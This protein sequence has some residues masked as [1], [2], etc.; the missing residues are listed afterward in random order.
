MGMEQEIRQLFVKF[1]ELWMLVPAIL[2]RSIP[3]G[4]FSL[5]WYLR[6]QCARRSYYFGLTASLE[7]FRTL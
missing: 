4:N 2:A 1:R 7:R 6:Y 5:G 3:A